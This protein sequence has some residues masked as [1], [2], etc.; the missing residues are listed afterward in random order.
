MTIPERLNYV[1]RTHYNMEY[2]MFN[3]LII[4]DR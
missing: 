2:T 1:L 3:E 4:K